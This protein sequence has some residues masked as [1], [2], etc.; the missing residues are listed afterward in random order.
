[1]FRAIG[2][3]IILYAIANM[4]NPA[5]ESFQDAT[6]ATFGAIETAAEVTSQQLEVQMQTP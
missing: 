6:V 3:V 5:F 1:M 2:I 4:M